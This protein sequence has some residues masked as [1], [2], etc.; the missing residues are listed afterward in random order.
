[1]I[2]SLP[3]FIIFAFNDCNP[4]TSSESALG[5]KWRAGDSN[6]FN[7]FSNSL[8][9]ESTKG[10]ALWAQDFFAHWALANQNFSIYYNV[11]DPCLPDLPACD[12][13]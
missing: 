10:Q 13:F 3:P 6:L 1:L 2:V 5:A 12:R 7:E 11:T 9:N 8:I 4:P